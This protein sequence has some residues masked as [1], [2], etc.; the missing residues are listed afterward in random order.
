MAHVQR[1]IRGLTNWDECLSPF[2]A[3]TAATAPRGTSRSRS[4]GSD[5]PLQDIAGCAKSQLA[6]RQSVNASLLI[7][8]HQCPQHTIA[9]V[10]IATTQ[11]FVFYHAL[12][13]PT[14]VVSA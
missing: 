13:Q 3:W 1:G 6:L 9:G 2:E 12:I 4:P 14:T 5:S 8:L 7:L 10:V 11:C